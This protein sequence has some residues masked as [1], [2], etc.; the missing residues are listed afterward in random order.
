[1]LRQ[2][3]AG[4]EHKEVVLLWIAGS[5]MDLLAREQE[6]SACCR[7]YV[8]I[9]ALNPHI[10]IRDEDS[11]QAGFDRSLSDGAMAPRAIRIRRVHVQI[12]DDF[13][14]RGTLDGLG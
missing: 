3:A 4:S 5:I 2:L 9:N 10:V 12:Q 11:I 14:H 7:L 6:D 8:A 13:D 1:V